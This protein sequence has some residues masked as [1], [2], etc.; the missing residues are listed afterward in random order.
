MK[1]NALVVVLF[2]LFVLSNYA[3]A[4]KNEI[5]LVLGATFS[6][7]TTAALRA[8]SIIVECPTCPP[9]HDQARV[10][11]KFSFEALYGRRI[12][13]SPV[14]SLYLE[15]PVVF[16]PSRG[17]R[18]FPLVTV[19]VFPPP[20]TF[21]IT[22]PHDFSSV[23]VTP[24]VK[25]K[26]LPEAVVAPFISAGGGIAHFSSTAR[27]SGFF[28]HSSTT[29]NTT[30]ALH[31]GVGVDFKTPLPHLGVRAEVRDFWTERP[32]FSLE[33]SLNHHHNVFAGG[34]IVFHF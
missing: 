15:L 6:P 17:V 10:A 3:S 16:V 2:L 21:V 26:L 29:S 19:A 18:P 33:T 28:N 4:Q 30:G 8:S 7:D 11:T 1:T 34:G 25:V 24:S 13:H 20:P 9:I 22:V 12:L 5:S 31:V 27:E 23:F 14:A 32:D